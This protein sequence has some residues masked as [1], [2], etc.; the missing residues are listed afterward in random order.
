LS[1]NSWVL[2]SF[3]ASIP[4]IY[5]LHVT[6]ID[7][8]NSALSIDVP[9]RPAS[10]LA[11]PRITLFYP[12]SESINNNAPA[13]LGLNEQY[14]YVPTGTNSFKFGVSVREP[15]RPAYGKLVDPAGIEYPFNYGTTT[16]KTFDSPAPGL[17][18]ININM[19][20]YSGNFWLVGIP[21][22]VWHDPKYLLV[23]AGGTPPPPPT[24]TPGDLNKDGKV[25]IFDVS[26]LLSKWASI[27]AVD[28]AEA[29]INA[30]PNNISQGKIDLYDA[31]KL[32]ANWRP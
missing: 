9:N 8:V 12:A 16:A 1:P 24:Y 27:L 19:T 21:P 25:N 18:K 10:I 14:F 4:G 17:W 29:D 3:H 30:G 23:Q 2:T 32:M 5:I 11:D 6:R 31:N 13:Y 22:L 28:L 7:P 15:S 26:I 20:I